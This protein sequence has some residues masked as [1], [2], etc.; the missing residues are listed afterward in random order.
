MNIEIQILHSVLILIIWI[1]NIT[2]AVKFCL[3]T[4]ISIRRFI[5]LDRYQALKKGTKKVEKKVPEKKLEAADL[6]NVSWS[7]I[8]NVF[9][10]K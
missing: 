7:K 1:F 9:F 3:Y 6:L 10:G 4:L 2:T 5:L 8:V